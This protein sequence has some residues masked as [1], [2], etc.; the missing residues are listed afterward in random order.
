MPK[1][2]EDSQKLDT[3]NV[4][5]VSR[6]K[7]KLKDVLQKMP[8]PNKIDREKLASKFPISYQNSIAIFMHQEV[9]KYSSLLVLIKQ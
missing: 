5:T 1:I 2:K 9:E 7:K 3:D 4:F 6:Y 8:S